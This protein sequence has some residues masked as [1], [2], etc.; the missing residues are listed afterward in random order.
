MLLVKLFDSLLGDEKSRLTDRPHPGSRA[1]SAERPVAP[2]GRETAWFILNLLPFLLSLKH[3][4]LSP[5]LT[6]AEEP[7]V[8]E[9]GTL[10]VGVSKEGILHQLQLCGGQG[11][12][13]FVSMR[14]GS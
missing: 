8:I 6:P 1:G 14:V 5:R 7:A 12:V 11:G 3:P 9:P 4:I 10:I 2:L 13:R